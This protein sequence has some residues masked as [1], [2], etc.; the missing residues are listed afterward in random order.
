MLSNCGAGEDLRVPW[1]AK[2]SN[3]SIL[4]ETNFEYSL[5]GLM[6]KLQYFDHLVWSANS[7][8]KTLMSGKIEGRRRRGRRGWDGWMA[9]MDMSLSKFWELVMDREAWRAAVHGVSKSRTPL[10]HWTEPYS[11]MMAYI[12]GDWWWIHQPAPSL[13]GNQGAGLSVPFSNHVVLMATSPYPCVGFPDVFSGTK[14]K[15]PRIISL[16]LLLREF[17]EFEELWA[18]NCGWMTKYKCLVLVL[19][20]TAKY[21]FPGIE[22]AFLVS[23][24]L[25]V[26]I[27]LSFPIIQWE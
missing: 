12:I 22:P 6:L 21:T 17:Q 10:S 14:D 18:R 23:P 3:Q 16:P 15:R 7:L 13:P 24:A 27:N 11:G 9:S 4:K 1:T 19:I 25:Q 8:E 26:F 20:W 5:E 2:R